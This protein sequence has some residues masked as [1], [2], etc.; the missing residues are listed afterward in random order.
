[1]KTKNLQPASVNPLSLVVLLLLP[2]AGHAEVINILGT[3]YYVATLGL[4]VYQIIY[5][6][7]ALVLVVLLYVL[8]LRHIRWRWLKWG[9]LPFLYAGLAALPYWDTYQI[10]QQAKV[11]CEEQ[12][13][14]Y[15][16]RTVEAD[17]FIGYTS[18]KKWSQYGFK[19]VEGYGFH[20]TMV[21]GKPHKER[22]GVENYRS[23]Y[24]VITKQHEPLG[25]SRFSR[26]RSWTRDRQTD[27][28][29]GEVIAFTVP[30]GKWD[31]LILGA[32][33]FAFNSWIC[34]K[35]VPEELQEKYGKTYGRHDL[36][37]AT[38]KPM[39]LQEG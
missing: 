19:Y 27:E 36:I 38:L 28:V 34:G 6:P 25:E 20:V 31:S 15:V 18:I 14:L 24:S 29:L 8:L 4:L 23:R 5:L 37:K 16:Y 2:A 35:T 13:G 9:M 30:P 10:G 1:M 32:S 39:L 33:G 22:V 11:L 17:G 3:D 7:V 26:H 12:A 21:D